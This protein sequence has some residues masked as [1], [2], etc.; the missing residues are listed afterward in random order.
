MRRLALR[1]TTR[2]RAGRVAGPRAPSVAC[3]VT[4]ACFALATCG[5]QEGNA[6]AAAGARTGGGEPRAPGPAGSAPVPTAEVLVSAAASLT[7][8][9]GA[10]ATAFEAAN[11]GVDVVLNLA[12][13][14]TLRQQILEGAP[15]DV[16][17]SADES[18]MERVVEA[19]EAAGPP[20]V[21]AR[22]RLRI[23]VPPGNPA[24]VTGLA[25]FADEGLLVGLC[26]EAVP[27]GAF[28]R[29]ALARAGVRPAVDT[30]EPDVRS[31][32][33]KIALGEL[34]AGIVYATDVAPAHRVQG[35]AIPDDENV[36]ARYPIVLL[37]HA[38]E[39]R[40]GAAFVAFVL[41]DGGQEI[42]RQ[43][44]FVSP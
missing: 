34:D 21:F 22:N 37:A 14:S 44:G 12:G 15:A 31:L 23:A 20:A 25:D 13:S 16:F 41:S 8:A 17:A 19:G 30:E 39:P 5:G 1:R 7:D 27:C 2:R 32:L 26:A 10:V 9:F 24:G 38:P 29:R 6:P 42:L 40:A 4:A 36:T 11:P 33:T 18:N 35:I 3:L 43:H 28:A